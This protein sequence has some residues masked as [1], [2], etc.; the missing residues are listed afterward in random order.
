MRGARRT[1]VPIPMGAYVA[2]SCEGDNAADGPFFSSLLCAPQ[3]RVQD[4]PQPVAHPA[5]HQRREHEDQAGKGG[6]PP[7]GVQVAAPLRS[8]DGPLTILP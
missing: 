6:D 4:I 7:G 5:H 8:C 3:R 1:R 2:A